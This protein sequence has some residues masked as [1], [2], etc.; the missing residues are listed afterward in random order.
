MH[1]RARGDVDLFDANMRRAEPAK[2]QR[3]VTA[4]RRVGGGVYQQQ[5][6]AGIVCGEVGRVVGARAFP[7]PQ[8]MKGVV[9][10]WQW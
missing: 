4:T 3:T 7:P 10:G 1:T 8:A 5:N 6:A 9:E 2:P